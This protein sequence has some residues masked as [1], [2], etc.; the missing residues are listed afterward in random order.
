MAVPEKPEE[1]SLEGSC[2]CAW[3]RRRT[4][5][6]KL[7]LLETPGV[8]CWRAVGRAAGRAQLQGLEDGCCD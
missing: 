5:D 1:E 6:S 8:L 2:V 7:D 4:A 3:R